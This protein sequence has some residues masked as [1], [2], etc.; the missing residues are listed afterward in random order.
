LLR[1]GLATFSLRVRYATLRSCRRGHALAQREQR[2]HVRRVLQALEEGNE[3]QEV[4][5]GGVADPAFDGD[6]IV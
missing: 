3:V 4:V 2:A 6:G 5:V 1:Y